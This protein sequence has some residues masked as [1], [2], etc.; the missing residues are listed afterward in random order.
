MAK[1]R[2]IQ[3][4]YYDIDFISSGGHC[5]RT[6]S[7]VPYS[8]IKNYRK[9]AKTLGETIKATKTDTIKTEII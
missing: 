9:L 6:L 8:E 1:K 7:N 3:K 4:T 2:Y 5:Y